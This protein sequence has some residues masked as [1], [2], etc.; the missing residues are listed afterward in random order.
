MRS[1][2]PRLS[3]A[4]PSE[5][6]ITTRE[7]VADL[8]HFPDTACEENLERISAAAGRALLRVGGVPVTEFRAGMIVGSGSLSFEMIRDLTERL[9]IMVCPRWVYSCT[10][11]VAIGDVL[12]YLVMALQT[13]A[14]I[15]QIIEIGG[16]DVLT[17]ADMMRG[18]A[19]VRGLRRLIIPVP[20]LTPKLSAYWI[21]LVTP[22]PSAIAM[23]L[24]NAPSTRGPLHQSPQAPIRRSASNRQ[25]SSSGLRV[26]K[27]LSKRITTATGSSSTTMI[28]FIRGPLRR[29][30]MSLW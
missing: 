4:P 3:F 16:P 29:R 5:I 28:T 24:R 10:Q 2:M 9:P 25:Q 12:T 8:A 15:D 23:P 30:A 18:Y 14:S 11:P 19:Q 22:V 6:S 13:E 7:P 17:Y 20:V 1:R 26:M 27:S 21:H